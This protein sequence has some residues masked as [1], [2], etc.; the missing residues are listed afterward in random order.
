[1]VSI[2]SQSFPRRMSRCPGRDS[3]NALPKYD[4]EALPQC[5]PPARCRSGKRHTANGARSGGCSCCTCFWNDG[6][7]QDALITSPQ[8]SV[9][10]TGTPFPSAR[11]SVTVPVDW[12]QFGEA[13]ARVLMLAI[14]G[15]P[16]SE[17]QNPS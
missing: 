12:A 14:S 10:V 6:V 3:K 15:V 9:R 2:L 4:H 8:Q 7:A 5:Q 17:E 13:N 11:S 16:N 1:M